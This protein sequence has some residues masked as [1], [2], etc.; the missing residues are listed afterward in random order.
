MVT[1]QILQFQ[2]FCQVRNLE[3][4]RVPMMCPNDVMAKYICLTAT[5]NGKKINYSYLGANK[6]CK[7]C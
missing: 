2:H 3:S 6:L 5:C 1:V 7:N 4:A